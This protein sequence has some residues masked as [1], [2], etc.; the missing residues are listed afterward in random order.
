MMRNRSS[1]QVEEGCQFHSNL[2]QDLE[3]PAW[4]KLQSKSNSLLLTVASSLRISENPGTESNKRKV[5]DKYTEPTTQTSCQE[6]QRTPTRESHLLFPA[7]HLKNIILLC[8]YNQERKRRQPKG[9]CVSV[10]RCQFRMGATRYHFVLA[11]PVYLRT[12]YP[13]GYLLFV[14]RTSWNACNT[15]LLV[16]RQHATNGSILN[17]SATMQRPSIDQCCTQKFTLLFI[18]FCG[19]WSTINSPSAH[20]H[21]RRKWCVHTGQSRVQ[22]AQSFPN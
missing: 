12:L 6:L 7:C 14:V 13:G 4:R 1:Y 21:P 16:Q 20:P 19:A 5:K 22:G 17:P 10:L 11:F 15:Y 18:I 2:S 9:T 3:V 8:K